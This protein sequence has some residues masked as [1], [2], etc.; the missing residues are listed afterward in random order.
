MIQVTQAMSLHLNLPP[1][2]MNHHQKTIKNKLP[3][4]H[5]I[6]AKVNL[7]VK[8]AM[9]H[10]MKVVAHPQRKAILNHQVKVKVTQVV[11]KRNKLSPK[12]AR[13]KVKRKIRNQ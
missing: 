11:K 4:L 2:A 13:K 9:N 10:Q 5:P 6:A 12:A 1:K 7:L 8:T 3:N